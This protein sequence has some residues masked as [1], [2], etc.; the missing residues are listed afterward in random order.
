MKKFFSLMLAMVIV[1]SAFVFSATEPSKQP[2]EDN[3]TLPIVVEITDDEQD[4]ENQVQPRAMIC[5]CGG[6]FNPI[7]TS[8]GAWRYAGSTA[9]S[10]HSG[11]TD[12]IET[13]SVAVLYRCTKCGTTYTSDSSE[14]RV[15]CTYL[16]S[17][18]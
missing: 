18:V 16:N 1:S 2:V 12:R 7:S 10:H 4:V 15:F 5:S 13:R 9:C 11:Y 8:Y 3:D 14:S 17:Y 6:V